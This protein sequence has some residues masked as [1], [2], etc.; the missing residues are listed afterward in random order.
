MHRVDL[1]G[2]T[3][4]C[5]DWTSTSGSSWEDDIGYSCVDYISEGYCAQYGS[6][7]DS[8]GSGYDSSGYDSAS[9]GV[10]ANEAC[11]ICGGGVSNTPTAM[12][13]LFAD[14]GVGGQIV[15]QVVS[16]SRCE[17]H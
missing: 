15:S 11:C 7:Y 6:G 10:T 14:S 16:F 3:A 17:P 2:C 8:E 1:L 5:T 12:P 13:T 4:A 9:Q